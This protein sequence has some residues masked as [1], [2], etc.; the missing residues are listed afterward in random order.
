M[1]M[2]PKSHPD[3][4]ETLRSLALPAG[5]PIP[6]PIPTSTARRR[7]PLLWMALLASVAFA[8]TPWSGH[9]PRQVIPRQIA[10]KV[11]GTAPVLA[12]SAITTVQQG[13]ARRR[14]HHRRRQR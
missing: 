7:L 10:A 8:Y 3:L 4:A 6:I 12:A 2:T 9:K 1:N 5:T 13:A 11:E 14:L